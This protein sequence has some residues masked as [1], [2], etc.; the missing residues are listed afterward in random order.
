MFD[1]Q[2]KG[3]SPNKL[4]Q[5]EINIIQVSLAYL[6]H[7]RGSL[8]MPFLAETMKTGTKNRCVIE[9]MHVLQR[10]LKKD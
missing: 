9:A 1:I 7:K 6:G 10:K 3:H 4:N 5:S 2:L 8:Q